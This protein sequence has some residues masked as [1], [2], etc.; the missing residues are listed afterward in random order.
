MSLGMSLGAFAEN[1]ASS[2]NAARDRTERKEA[3][4]QQDRW[5][6]ILEKNPG[7]M[8]GQSPSLNAG[9]F[10]LPSLGAMPGAGDEAAASG[11]SGYGKAAGGGAAASGGL[12]G[13]I[14]KTEGAGNYDTL[15]GHAQNG[16]QFAGTRVSDMTLDQLGEFAAPSGAYGQWV[17]GKVGRVATPMGRHQIVGTTL[18]NAA[19]ELGLSGDTKFSG[20]VQDQ[21]AN[22]LAARR[23]AS[24]SSPEA[25]RDALR[26]EW[27]GFQS[28]PDAQLDS[29]IADFRKQRAGMGATRPAY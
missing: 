1:F 25:A 20:D 21:I 7:I 8:Y 10:N 13:L 6:D 23:L 4:A 12:F 27:E 28:V 26:A 19:K 22:H 16:G 17:K 15:F 14:D 18:R 11:G 29:A 9:Q 5:L 3:S 2:R 24:A